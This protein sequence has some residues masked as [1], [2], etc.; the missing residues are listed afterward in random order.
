MVQ[1]G[2]SEGV[3]M[4]IANRFEGEARARSHCRFVPPLIHFIPDSL[5]LLTYSLPLFLQRQCDRTLGEGPAVHGYGVPTKVR[6]T[7][8]RPSSNILLGRLPP[9][10][11]AFP[12]LHGPT[13]IFW[14]SLTPS[15]L[16]Q[17]LPQR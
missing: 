12:P 2:P 1:E 9:F 14:S 4:A 16:A 8:S 13:W 15:F 17:A 11:A 6:E 7:P 5:T 3:V 10:I